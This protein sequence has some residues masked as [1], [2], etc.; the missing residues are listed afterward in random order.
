MPPEQDAACVACRDEGLATDAAAYDPKYPV[1]GMDE[2]PIQLLQE[3]RA[4]IAVTPKHSKRAAYEYE[5]HGTASIF[6]VAAPLSG[7]RPATARVWAHHSR[8]GDRSRPD[9]GHALCRWR[10]GATRL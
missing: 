8:L 5:R 1:L 4:P 6:M 2:P 10:G 9:V 7:F 3:T